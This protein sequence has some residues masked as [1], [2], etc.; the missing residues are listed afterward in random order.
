MK[1]V[2]SGNIFE[3][4]SIVQMHPE[5]FRPEGGLLQERMEIPVY[6]GFSAVEDRIIS[7]GFMIIYQQLFNLGATKMD[8]LHDFHFLTMIF[9]ME[10]YA[11]FESTKSDMPNHDIAGGMHRL[12]FLPSVD[13]QLTYAK[14]RRAIEISLSL[15]F[16]NSL[17]EH[18]LG[19]L[20]NFGKGI[21]LLESVLL[22]DKA[23]P[24]TLSMYQIL[25]D[26]IYCK[27]S[28]SLKR[29]YLQSK[30]GELLML[31]L[32]QVFSQNSNISK[33]SK[34]DRDK[35]HLVKHLIEI[36]MFKPLTI[37]ELAKL[38]GIN[39]SKLKEVFK[40][41]F[42][43]TIFG[44]LTDLRLS[45]AKSSLEEGE[46]SIGDIAYKLGYKHPQ[47]FTFAFKRKFGFAPSKFKR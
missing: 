11:S 19:H 17:F 7:G 3:D 22:T 41:E 18:D 43:T 32:D 24:I 31:Q 37:P 42:G 6:K 38:A 23:L 9:E 45:L 40:T 29:I 34:G 25:N 44:Y 14:S 39:T 26:I 35:A 28:G 8:V 15:D 47:H 5:G 10:G 12:M 16:F 4:L 33:F 21:N 2:Y 20:G 27:F 30:I 1:T 36:N 13:G 46:L